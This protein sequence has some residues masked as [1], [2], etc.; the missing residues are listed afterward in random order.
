AS[1]VILGQRDL[2]IKGAEVRKELGEGMELMAIPG[3]MPPHSDLGEPLSGQKEGTLVA[4]ARDDFGEGRTKLDFELHILPGRDRM[5]Q[6]NFKYRLVVRIAV[7][8]R[9]EFHLP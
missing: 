8:R 2:H 7:V 9:D 5:R 3:I 1:D 4:G 6:L